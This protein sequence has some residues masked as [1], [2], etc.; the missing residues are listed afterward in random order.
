MDR[1][2][3]YLDKLITQYHIQNF[4]DS[5]VT[6]YMDKIQPLFYLFSSYLRLDDDC[7]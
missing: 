5:Q 6:A 4:N 1:N 3:F 7:S 2:D